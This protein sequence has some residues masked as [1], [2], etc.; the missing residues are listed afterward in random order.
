MTSELDGHRYQ[1]DC[2]DRDCGQFD[3]VLD[4]VDLPEVVAEQSNATGPHHCADRVGDQERVMSHLA[5]AGQYRNER[6]NDGNEAGEHQSGS[7]V[8]LEEDVGSGDVPLTEKA[9]VRPVEHGRPDLATDQIP[10]LTAHE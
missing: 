4:D 6:A 10:D 7:A 5:D 2:N 8:T 1:R 3:V 9:R